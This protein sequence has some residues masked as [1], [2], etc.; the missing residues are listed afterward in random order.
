MIVWWS[1]EQA[2]ATQSFDSPLFSLPRASS[3]R[4]IHYI[5]VCL[6]FT[7]G[8]LALPCLLCWS[9]TIHNHCL[10]SG[11]WAMSMQG[12]E[13]PLLLW[14]STPGESWGQVQAHPSISWKVTWWQQSQT[15]SPTLF[16]GMTCVLAWRLQFGCE[17]LASLPL[18]GFLHFH[19]ELD[20]QKLFSQT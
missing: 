3:L 16:P 12:N 7:S 14:P 11:D 20:V 2:L 19:F 15:R 10:P 6:V 8:L 1:R 17:G 9:S 13:I 5:I 18:I 4:W